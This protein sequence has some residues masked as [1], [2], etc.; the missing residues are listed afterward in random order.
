[1]SLLARLDAALRPCSIEGCPGGKRIKRG[2]CD[3]I[4]EPDGGQVMNS[5]IERVQGW[6]LAR[7]Q[8]ACPWPTTSGAVTTKGATMFSDWPTMPSK[9]PVSPVETT[10]P[11]AG[12]PEQP[13]TNES[14]H[15]AAKYWRER[16]A[17]RV[18]CDDLRTRLTERDAQVRRLTK[19]LSEGLG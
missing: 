13:P 6:L 7:H 8:R 4:L 2:F 19:R 18:E 16:Q 17:L 11:L 10:E 12:T 5:L 15:L 1:M 14:P 3:A 9:P